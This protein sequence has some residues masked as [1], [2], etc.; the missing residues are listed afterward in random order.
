MLEKRYSFYGVFM[1]FLLLSLVISLSA[2][3]GNRKPNASVPQE[4]LNRLKALY[5]D[6]S[7]AYLYERI[8]NA[9]TAF[10]KWRAFPPYFYDLTARAISVLGNDF[11]SRSGLCA[12]DP[13]LENFGYIYMGK[14]AFSLNDLDDVAPCSLNADALRLFVGHRLV[15]P[16]KADEW[17]AEYKA[18]LAG[19]NAS[20]PSYIEEIQK[21]SKKGKEQMP[22]KYRKL[23][24]AGACSG[25]FVAVSKSETE[26]VSSF[27]ITEGRSLKF[28][29]SRTKNS[30]GSAGNKRF[31]IFSSA[32]D[33]VEAFELKPLAT[34][35]PIAPKVLSIPERGRLFQQAVAV[36]LG[37]NFSSAYYPVVMGNKIYQRRPLW[38][39]NVGVTEKNLNSKEVKEV[40]L[41]QAR[42]LGKHHRLT[43]SSPFPYSP[44]VWERMAREIEKKWR[45][46][47]AE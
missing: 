22:K 14:P 26:L 32:T 34:P 16:V 12:G 29:C 2:F 27:L 47:F 41:Y 25:D 46:D 36:Y 38:D 18:G 15:S 3:A 5:P 17:I 10:E 44:E 30:G 21:E 23:L 28:I 11:K 42:I 20:G 37:A 19:Q 40:S 13:H 7:E 45:Q 33:G 9:K 24:E 6:Q 35:A 8:N 1:K 39:G 31:V 4:T 43:N